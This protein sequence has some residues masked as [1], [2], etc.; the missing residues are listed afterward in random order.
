[1]QP[2]GRRDDLDVVSGERSTPAQVQVLSESLGS[3]VEA[4]EI[5]EHATSDEHAGGG[6]EKDAPI[7][8][9]LPLVELTRIDAIIHSPGDVDAGPDRLEPVRIVGPAQLRTDDG[10]TL[11]GNPSCD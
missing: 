2:Y 5:V 6:Y 8:V 10:D 4:P 11:I 7:S 3:W 9:T 1:M